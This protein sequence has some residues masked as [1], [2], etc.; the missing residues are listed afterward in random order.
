MAHV[1]TL[2]VLRS[3]ELRVTEILKPTKAKFF[4]D[5][6]V[7]DTIEITHELEGLTGASGGG[8]YAPTYRLV[9]YVRNNKI[10]ISGNNLVNRL[11]NF[12]LETL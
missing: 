11:A 8:L 2:V 6:Q 9:N 10:S 3:G 12:K 4:K 5:I 7:G 1:K